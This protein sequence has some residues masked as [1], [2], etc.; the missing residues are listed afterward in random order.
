[1]TIQQLVETAQT[2]LK[3]GVNTLDELENYLIRAVSTA[4]FEA[5]GFK[6][7]SANDFSNIETVAGSFLS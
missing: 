4:N 5:R 2:A 1:M 7:V 3:S 6:I